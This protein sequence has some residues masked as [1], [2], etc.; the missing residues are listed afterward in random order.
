M[1]SNHSERSYRRPF[2]PK[3]QQY[4]VMKKNDGILMIQEVIQLRNHQSSAG[5]QDYYP[6]MFP[7][8]LLQESLADAYDSHINNRD[9]CVHDS[10]VYSIQYRQR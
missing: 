7:K 6:V 5:I 9:C 4:K 8:A 1:L 10:T 2:C 3:I